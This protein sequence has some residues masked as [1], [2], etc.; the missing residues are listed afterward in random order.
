MANDDYIDRINRQY[1]DGLLSAMQRSHLARL[2]TENQEA[3]DFAE[4]VF[5]RM[6]R[7]NISAKDSHELIF[8]EIATIIPKILPGTWRGVV[9]P[10][11]FQDRHV[12][13]EEFMKI[14]HYHPVVAGSQILDMGCGFPPF[15]AIDLS[16]KFPEASITA[17]DPSFGKY[18]VTDSH[19][20]YAVIMQ[21]GSIKY[22]QPSTNSSSSWNDIF[23]DLP[24]TIKRF[25]EMFQSLAKQLPEQ[26]SP[27]NYE[28]YTANGNTIVRNPLRKYASHN[29]GF[30]QKAIGDDSFP[31]DYDIIRCMNVLLYFDPVFRANTLDWAA[32]HLRE[33]GLFICG[34]NWAQSVNCR[35]SIYQKE[36]GEMKLRE[37]CFSIENL[38]PMEIVSYFSFRNDDFDQENL[39]TYSALIRKDDGLMKSFNDGM[40]ELLKLYGLGMRDVNGYLVFAIPL[41]MT[42][43]QINLQKTGRELSNKYAPAVVEIL[44]Q[45]GREA[46]VNEI[47][48][49]SIGNP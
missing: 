38:R 34:L 21:D 17:S 30:V 49:I 5:A 45:H 24:A 35:L 23:D 40:D 41:Q 10:I 4:N 9:P 26:E 1:F 48:F 20:N 3:V 36:N 2:D 33:G 28:E 37:F 31:P 11:T 44:K 14:N 13:V 39:L 6:K 12:L 16:L 29:L 25:T 42:E 19:G 7:I 43:F 18:T 27:D 46:W 32:R 47:G 22:L 8:W 15:T